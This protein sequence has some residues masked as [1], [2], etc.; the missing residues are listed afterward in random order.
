M[1][2]GPCGGVRADGSCEM[3]PRPCVFVGLVDQEPASWATATRV[4]APAPLV[5]TDLSTPAADAATLTATA[6]DTRA[7]LRCG[8]GR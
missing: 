1:I 4:P 6:A 7:E 5:L 2:F 8:A 3:A